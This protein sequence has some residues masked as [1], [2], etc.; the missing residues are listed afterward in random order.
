[1]GP[2]VCSDAVA[3]VVGQGVRAATRR[4]VWVS[5]A[6]LW[7]GA[8]VLVAC[9]TPAE[10]EALPPADVGELP[11]VV[12]LS[13][14]TVTAWVDTR[15]L[16]R[17]SGFAFG[18]TAWVG[19]LEV[20]SRVD[21]TNGLR[22]MVP[23]LP[24]GEY[25]V[26]VMNPTGATSVQRGALIVAQRDVTECN[27]VTLP[28]VSFQTTPHDLVLTAVAATVGCLDARVDPIVIEGYARDHRT[29][30]LSLA[31]AYRRAT[32]VADLLSAA[33]VEDGRLAVV[34]Y[35][36]EAPVGDQ[37]PEAGVEVRSGGNAAP[38]VGRYGSFGAKY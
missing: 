32:E 6:A 36:A 3:G 11:Q 9:P 7:C 34:S 1:M 12:Q 25:D 4:G 33:G 8:A 28:F 17:G 37:G 35:G 23:S 13:P 26:R 29:T 31:T 19:D 16:A 15:V 10:P 5:V 20:V 24:P 2:T 30:E 38:R 21:D 27:R 22:M 14:G 18:A